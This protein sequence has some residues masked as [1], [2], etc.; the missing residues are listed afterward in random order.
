MTDVV[1][2]T[3]LDEWQTLLGD[4]DRALQFY[5]EHILPPVIRHLDHLPEHAA[6]RARGCSIL[7]STMGFSPETTVIAASVLRPR[8]LIVIA[9]ETNGS[10]LDL[11][12]HFL[13]RHGIMT[14]SAVRVEDV[15][16]TDPKQIYDSIRRH[17]HG[18]HDGSPIMD[19]TGGKKIM[20]ATAAVAAW[21][22]RIP[23]CYVEGAYDR[24]RRRPAP[25]TERIILLRNPSQEHARMLRDRALQWYERGSMPTAIE[26]FRESRDAQTE[27]PQLDE[28]ALQLARCES[29]LMDL[30]LQ[31]LRREVV[32]LDEMLARPNIELLT[33][34]LP[35]KPHAAAL[36]RVAHG[37]RLALLATFRQLVSRY[38]AQGRYD[39]A[40]LLAYRT[41]EDLVQ[42]GLSHASKTGDFDMSE[43]DLALLTDDLAG[44]QQRYAALITKL[45]HSHPDIPDKITFLAG[46]ILLG[47][48][49][50]VAARLR[51][52]PDLLKT[53]RHASGLAAMRNHSVLAHGTRNLSE[54]DVENLCTFEREL[55][56]AILADGAA[57][58]EQL[59][60]D[61]AP[62]KLRQLVR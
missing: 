9:S 1:E 25:G 37:D 27:A 58:V 42:I 54:R 10:F 35:L 29:A 14:F 45:G 62:P 55:T 12:I 3:L 57:A 19:V 47:L 4:T 30:D 8:R 48:T 59:E 5:F 50:D 36:R 49:T 23:L 46:L 60:R 61:L 16:P 7:V 53:L 17:F 39:F 21:E 51:T 6:L 28:L 13:E 38:R 33:Q 11:A 2:P 15:D 18:G 22:L 24:K 32:V 41:F 43:P 31:E 34:D 20:S 44:I 52:P 40:S 56:R 26:A